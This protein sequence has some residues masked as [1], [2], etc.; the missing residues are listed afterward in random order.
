MLTIG[1][2][3]MHEVRPVL[4]QQGILSEISTKSARTQNH[5]THF[6]LISAIL[7]VHQSCATLATH[8][9]LVGLRFRDDPGPVSA[10]SDLFDH[11]NQ[12]ICNCHARE[13]LLASMRTWCRVTTEPSNQREIQIK[14]VNQP[15]HI[16]TAVAAQHLHHLGLLCSTFQ[17]VGCEQLDRIWDSLLLLSLG[18]CTIDATGCLGRVSSAK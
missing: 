14:L 9:Q 8:D 13:A 10:L 12:C 11:L 3:Q 2:G 15:I 5:W 4:S 16:S 17:S 18:G 7:F 6:S 1:C